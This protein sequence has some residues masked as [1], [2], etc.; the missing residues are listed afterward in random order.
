MSAGSE[1]HPLQSASVLECGDTSPLT[2]TRHVTSFQPVAPESNAGG[3]VDVSAHSKMSPRTA[4]LAL[5]LAIVSACLFG[6]VLNSHSGYFRDFQTVLLQEK[7]MLLV[8]LAVWFSTFVFL[9][10][11]RNDLLLIGLLL[12]A[13]A[14]FFISQAAARPA[15]DAIVLL[16][17]VTLGRGT[18][19]LLSR[20]S[21]HESAPIEQSEIRSQK[22]GIDQSELTSSATFLTGL[23]LL[24]AFASWWHL[25]TAHRFYPGT[26][27]TGLWYNPNDYG[28][29]MGAGIVLAA[30][31]LAEKLKS[32][33]LKAEFEKRKPTAI[34]FAILNPQSAILLVAAG[35][36]AVGLFFSYSHWPD[37]SGKGLREIQMAVCFAG[38]CC[39]C[40]GGDCFLAFHGGHRPVV[41][42]TNG[43]KPGIGA[44]PGVRLARGGSN[45][46]G[47][48][49]WRW[50]E[51]CGGC[52]P[53]KLFPA[54]RRRGGHHHE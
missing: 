51:Q 26:R 18:R 41:S 38:N 25:E 19:A 35:M 43:F 16:A 10:F 31:L 32:E 30:G 7:W 54:R 9:T 42:Q 47:P 21:Q 17:G 40:R 24:L 8:C 27:W 22:S 6:Y 15:V 46:V 33:T 29:L 49:V 1:N 5:L 50:L 44:T 37:L 14:A 11:S 3:S 23:V 39:R 20:S 45:D 2:T 12:I 48:S 53:E 13:M 36:M 4:K 34:K 28:M 52:L